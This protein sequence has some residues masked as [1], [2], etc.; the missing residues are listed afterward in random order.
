MYNYVAYLSMFSGTNSFCV[1][2][3]LVK[4]KII[5]VASIKV[6]SV[7]FTKVVAFVFYHYVTRFVSRN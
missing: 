6:L 3:V 1:R 5:F 2:I 4:I 7:C